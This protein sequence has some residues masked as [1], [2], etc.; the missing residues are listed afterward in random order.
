MR[1][2]LDVD[3]GASLNAWYTIWKGYPEAHFA[4]KRQRATP[5]QASRTGIDT[6]LSGDDVIS[7]PGSV[8]RLQDTSH[9]L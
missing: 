6:P 7:A 1:E 8:A 5:A 4:E 9:L 2:E 3:D